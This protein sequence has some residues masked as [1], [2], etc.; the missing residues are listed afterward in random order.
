MTTLP[1]YP[2]QLL[3][4]RDKQFLVWYE[5]SA[6]AHTRR[7]NIQDLSNFSMTSSSPVKI[8]KP[9]TEIWFEIFADVYP[10]LCSEK[11]DIDRRGKQ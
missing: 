9:K 2:K 1:P 8:K 11:C 4:S 5:C 6:L 7:K 3:I 10:C